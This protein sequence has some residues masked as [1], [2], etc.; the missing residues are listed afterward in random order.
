MKAGSVESHGGRCEGI[1]RGKLET[2]F[3]CEIGIYLILDI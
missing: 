3:V 2:Q 1:I